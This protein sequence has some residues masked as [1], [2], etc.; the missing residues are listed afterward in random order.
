MPKSNLLCWLLLPII[1]CS[2][3][4]WAEEKTSSTVIAIDDDFSIVAEDDFAW[5]EFI[6]EARAKYKK[7]NVVFHEKAQ[8][9]YREALAEVVEVA[10]EVH[11]FLLDSD[12]DSVEED[13]PPDK[14]FPIQPYGEGANAKILKVKVLRKPENQA[15]AQAL[16][17]GLRED[18]KG[19]GSKCHL[20]VYGVR[21]YRKDEQPFQSSFCWECEN[22]FV[23]YPDHAGWQEMGPAFDGILELFKEVIPLPAE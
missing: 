2:G 17:E 11:V 20:P 19:G 7:Q 9:N 5:S 10:D 21:I 4:L 18:L 22:Y 15:L 6:N 8:R 12:L 1:F 14:R 23:E 16:A 3:S 13:L